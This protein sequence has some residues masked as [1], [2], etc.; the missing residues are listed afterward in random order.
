MVASYIETEAPFLGDWLQLRPGSS[1]NATVELRCW[2]PLFCRAVSAHTLLDYGCGA[3]GWFNGCDIRPTRY[4]GVDVDEDTISYNKTVYPAIEFHHLEGSGHDVPQA[5]VVFCKDVFQHLPNDDVIS[6]LEAICET[7]ARFLITSLDSYPPPPT[8]ESRNFQSEVGVCDGNGY[9]PENLSIEP[10][11]LTNLV[12]TVIL[13][14]KFYQVWDLDEE[15][16]PHRV[17]YSITPYDKVL[18]SNQKVCAANVGIV[19][20]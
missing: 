11:L 16:I 14:N 7:R 3:R 1:C 6:T 9:I 13:D 10:F 5:D 4:V 12:G 8:N 15:P 20:V 2:L 17:L 19:N 18:L